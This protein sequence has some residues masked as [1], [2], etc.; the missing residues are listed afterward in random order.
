MDVTHRPAGI[1]RGS[2]VVG[3]AAWGR[4]RSAALA[5]LL[6]LVAA[7]ACE[8]AKVASRTVQLALPG[9]LSFGAG[10]PLVDGRPSTVAG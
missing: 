1:P 9:V 4:G 6:A 8:G 10:Y 7:A 5:A 2:G 3:I